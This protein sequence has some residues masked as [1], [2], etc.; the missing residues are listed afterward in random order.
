M[1][2]ALWLLACRP[3]PSDPGPDAPASGPIVLAGGGS[4]GEPGD[5]TS[6]SARL[7]G[8]LLDGG[9]VDGDGLVRV[10][11]LSAE[12]EDSWLPNYFVWLGADGADNVIT[13]TRAEAG[14]ADLSGYDAV[15]LKGGDQGV[16]YDQWNDTE[17]EAE[18]RRIHDLG[19]AIGG[20]SAGAMSLSDVALAGGEDLVT[21]D[22]L[23]D[24]QT[25]YLDDTDGGSGLKTDFRGLVGGVMIDTHFTSRA[26]LGR[27]TGALARAVDDLGRSDLL[28]IGLEEETGI[29]L[30]GRGATV[31]GVG[32]ANFVKIDGALNLRRVAGEPLLWTDLGL[33]RLTDGWRF[34]LDQGVDTTSPPDGA[35]AVAWDGTSGPVDGGWSARGRHP[36]DEERFETV[37]MRT[38][39][40]THAGADEPVLPDAVGLLDAFGDDEAAN[41]EAM[42][43]A[44]SDHVGATGFFVARDGVLH[45]DAGVISADDDGRPTSTVIV[46]TSTVSWRSWSPVASRYDLGDGSLHA[47]GMVGLRF[48]VLYTPTTGL[49]WDNGTRR[50]R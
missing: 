13:K 41:D 40:A 12:D 26:R 20:T 32:T 39:Y 29:V 35:T 30:Q 46:D 8:H 23:T 15:F 9:D 10:A 49:V 7:Y 47:A 5:L 48:S 44:L 16:Y 31:I 3:V 18:I 28:G 27:L 43:R 21:T 22:V 14:A 37:V 19:G 25:P 17:L 42:F 4:E 36:G 34:D 38:P 2:A 6:W 45:G 33:D 11:I 50:I 1:I 24:A